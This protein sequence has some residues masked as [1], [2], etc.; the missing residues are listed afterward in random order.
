MKF[1]KREPLNLS[2]EQAAAVESGEPLT[3]GVAQATGP[4]APAPASDFELAPSPS[5]TR[6]AP[7]TLAAVEPA[8]GR[9]LYAV[10]L[11]ASLLWAA[12]SVYALNYQL[13]IGGVDLQA[14]QTGVFVI[15]AIAPIGFIWIA[16]YCVRQGARLAA[17]VARTKALAADMLEPA[18]VAA[19]ETG[20]VVEEVRLEI[21]AATNAA[22]RARAE[23]LSLRQALADESAGL[24]ASAD[25]SAEAA[26]IL[27]KKLFQER[28]AMEGLAGSLDARSQA[29]TEAIGQQARM[30]AEASDLAQ[31][32]IGEAEAALAARATDLTTAAADAGEA[33]RVAS[34]DLARQV[35]RLETA[36]LGVSDQIVSM[37]DTLTQQRAALVQVAH[38]VRAD[39]EDFSIKVE[40]QQARL[41]DVLTRAQTSVA[42]LNEA[43]AAAAESLGKLTTA[44]SDQVQTLADTAASER[45]LLAASALQSL[46]ALSEAAKFERETLQGDLDV[47][48]RAMGDSAESE[49][50]RL[51]DEARNRMADLADAA[52]NERE[53]LQAEALEAL[54]TMTEAAE[55]SSQLAESYNEGARRKLEELS[56]SAFAASQQAETT[57][58]ARLKEAESLIAGSAQLIDQAAATTAER[59]DAAAQRARETL[60]ELEGALSEFEI[61][62]AQLPA[63]ARSHAEQLERTLA[64]GLDSL[65]ASARKA[66]EETQAID[67]A[68]QERV[69]RNYEMLSE[70]VRLMGVVSSSRGGPPITPSPRSALSP[71]AAP[72]PAAAR[73]EPATAAAARQ[74]AEPEP[75]AKASEPAEA[76][77]PEQPPKPARRFPF[78]SRPDPAASGL[79]PRL[80]LSPTASDAQITQ[81]FEAPAPAKSA[82]SDGDWT[83]Q[84]ILSSMDDAPVDDDQLAD[85]LIGEIEGL[86]VDVAALLPRSR[87]E[88][89][90]AVLE[91]GDEPGARSVVRHL[92]PAAVRRLSRRALAEPA[93]RSHA[94]RFVR[95][96]AAALKE[97]AGMKDGPEVAALLAT[98]HGR[99]YLLFDAAVGDLG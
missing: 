83:W 9:W 96:F 52:R 92:A 48:L 79:R 42:D 32:Q 81:V 30:V 93:L 68:F 71:S 65:L 76:P 17:E 99:V 46:G 47:T 97:A 35:A 64:A 13:P 66:A 85:R 14:Y 11:M 50:G 2:A 3:L 77:A 58:D 15:F 72:A 6:L 25:S 54:R 73:E 45:D 23:L 7:G 62:A 86:G 27:R 98:E 18:A 44:A 60:E 29:V 56:E 28:E 36:T 8:Y 80:K 75:A 24:T 87:I 89:I 21:D 88:E 16:V 5:R 55:T 22:A 39:H 41:A 10:A 40:S 53:A 61:R 69:R 59:L 4:L 1:N 12:F 95:G 51:E 49:R 26:R 37:E 43:A 33:S 78:G 74:A 82:A 31:A 90:G 70:A 34:E 57:F 94:E 67:T 19:A 38:A 63:E 84:D 20:A 91:A